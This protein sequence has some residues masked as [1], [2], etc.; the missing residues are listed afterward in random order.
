MRV[1]VWLAVVSLVLAQHP[2]IAAAEGREPD[3]VPEV[4]SIPRNP[5]IVPPAKREPLNAPHIVTARVYSTSEV[6]ADALRVALDVAQSAFVP[7]SV[8]INWKICRPGECNTPPSQ[9]ELLIRFMQSRGRHVDIRCLGEALIDKQKGI[10][11]LATVYVDRVLHLARNLELDQ[12]ILLGRTIAHEIGH[13]LLGTSTHGELGLMREV[14]SREELIGD[15]A[16][17]WILQP[18][19]NAALR[20]RISVS[21]QGEQRITTRY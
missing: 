19:E 3:P 21:R 4:E 9:G 20:K 16:D 2:G 10:G 6:G 17:H 18:F 11:V 1:H 8:E 7:A 13:L 15:Q 5:T 12:S 14:W